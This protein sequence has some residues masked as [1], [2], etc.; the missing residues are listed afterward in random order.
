MPR[1][2]GITDEEI[3]RM[4][5]SGM[6]F[7]E[8]G[9]I[10][11]LSDRG[12]RNVM[13]KHGI[14][15]NR[16]QSSGRPRK[17]KVNE[18]FFKEWSHEMAWVLGIFITDGHVNSTSHS[19]IFSQKDE[20]ILRI[21]ADYMQADY[22]LAPFGPT[23]QTPS[24]VINSK[25]IKK[26]LEEIGIGPKKSFTVPFPDVPEEFL[27][28]FVR[29]VIDGD[30]WVSKEGYL[31]HVTSASLAFSKGLQSVFQKWQL[32][33]I[34][35]TI[36]NQNIYRVWVKGKK[37]LIN[38]ASIIYK[39][40]NNNDFLI[41]KRVFMT[42]YSNNPYMVEDTNELPRWKIQNGK[43]VPISTNKRVSF[44][45]NISKEV[46]N[47]LEIK[48]KELKMHKNQLLENGLRNFLKQDEIVITKGIKVDRIQFKSTYEPELLESVKEVA[49]EHKVFINH[50]I[51]KSVEFIDIDTR[52]KLL[53]K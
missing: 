43:T 51:E 8:M 50:I 28:S 29:G 16:E 32:N 12:I 42:Q 5:K 35:S 40:A 45:T 39:T 48:A 41:H 3:I 19:I 11:G 25:E 49:K 26:D 47:S 10:I 44:R 2:P 15:M 13:Y 18:D 6:P 4:Y 1:N 24:L 46:L 34:I 27:P 7:K 30:G 22:V 31:S 52:K 53:I 33:S 23:M 17:H 36:K 14:E 37:D 21:I 9:P 20:R 38:L